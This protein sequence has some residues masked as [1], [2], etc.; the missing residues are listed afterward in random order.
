[1][2]ATLLNR[3]KQQQW[4]AVVSIDDDDTH[5]RMTRTKTPALKKWGFGVVEHVPL[6]SV[7]RTTYSLAA[8]PGRRDVITRAARSNSYCGRNEAHHTSCDSCPRRCW[9][10]QWTRAQLD[11]NPK[12][13]NIFLNRRRTYV[14]VA[15]QYSVPGVRRTGTDQFKPAV[16]GQQGNVT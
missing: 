8:G 3:D 16:E 13:K 15:H 5:D 7:P 6:R 12:V 9:S 4:I 14:Q 10:I 1:M 11:T 2:H